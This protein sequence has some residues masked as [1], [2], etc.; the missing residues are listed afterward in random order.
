MD[1]KISRLHILDSTRGICV[2]LMV[3]YHILFDLE[4]L[5]QISFSFTNTL[6]VEFIANI[7]RFVFIFL[8][9]VNSRIIFLNSKSLDIYTKKQLKRFTVLLSSAILVSIATLIFASNLFIYFGVLHLVSYS[10]VFFIAITTFKRFTYFLLAN[11]VL[12]LFLPLEYNFFYESSFNRASLDFF[13]VFPWILP[14]VFGYYSFD[15]LGK[16]YIK[17]NSI[18]LLF[19]EYLGKNSLVIYL[20]HQPIIIVL[21][22]SI[23][24]LH[25]LQVGY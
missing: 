5:Y 14:A 25:K 23:E 11:L 21:F 1:K 20:L 15:K 3:F 24:L 7:V 6:I 10:I 19:L 22:K 16:Y 17:F 4:F 9:G 8:V 18:R 13:S 12:F 2:L